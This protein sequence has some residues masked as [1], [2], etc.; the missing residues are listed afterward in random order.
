MPV[1]DAILRQ[2]GR[3]RTHDVNAL[4]AITVETAAE[5]I[6]RLVEAPEVKAVFQ[7]D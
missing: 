3:H 1:I 5:G 7:L 4:G 2:Q 6:R